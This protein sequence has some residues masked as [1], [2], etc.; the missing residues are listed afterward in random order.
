MRNGEKPH[1][2]NVPGAFYVVDGCCTAC[3][4][5]NTF[6]PDVFAFDADDHCYVK[7]QPRTAE[8][9]EAALRVVRTQELG[10]IRYRGT[11]P[12]ILR[13]LAEAGEAAQCDVAL[14]EG[15]LPVPRNHVT[16]TANDPE[17]CALS[18][19]A[20]LE[21]FGDYLLHRPHPVRFRTTPV[22]EGP[23]EAHFSI[24]WYEDHFHTVAIRPVSDAAGHWLVRHSFNVGLSELIDDWLRQSGRFGGVRWYTQHQ[25][26]GTRTWQDRPW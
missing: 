9:T 5:P 7:H 1:P 12:V 14:P 15:I 10:C 18:G 21:D 13:G 17:V 11:D 4:V 24:A 19:A 26:N 22:V 25:W 8:E 23:D 3:G 20:V 16:F 2:K 6:A